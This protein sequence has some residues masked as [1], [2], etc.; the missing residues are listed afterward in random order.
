MKELTAL[1]IIM[2]IGA[3]APVEAANRQRTGG[4][5]DKIEVPSPNQRGNAYGHQN[6]AN[7]HYVAPVEENKPTFSV[8]PFLQSS[9]H[10][11]VNWNPQ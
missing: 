11:C 3:S 1:W 5:R 10:M 7:P 9:P 6:S 4:G 8:C 2:L